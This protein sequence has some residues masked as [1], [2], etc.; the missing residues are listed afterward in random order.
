MS[1]DRK[2]DWWTIFPF[3]RK[4]LWRYLRNGLSYVCHVGLNIE[5]KEAALFARSVVQMKDVYCAGVG[6]LSGKEDGTMRR[7]EM[8]GF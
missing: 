2:A 3:C 5:Q 8:F 4:R 7:D 6:G 1:Q